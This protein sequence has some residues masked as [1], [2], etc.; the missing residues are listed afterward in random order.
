[1]ARIIG[2]L[3]PGC[4]V[5]VAHGQMEGHE[6]EDVMVKFIEGEFDVLGGDNHH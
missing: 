6:L 5:S 2:D 4:R 3:V 1:M